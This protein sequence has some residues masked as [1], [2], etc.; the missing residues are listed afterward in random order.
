MTTVRCA[1][2][3]TKC[4][5]APYNKSADRLFGL[6]DKPMILMYNLDS[7]DRRWP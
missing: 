4:C 6:F 3:R 7:L 1:A 2:N 5:C